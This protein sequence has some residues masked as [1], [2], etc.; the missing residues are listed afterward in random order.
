MSFT[1]G[2]GSPLSST[3]FEVVN[4]KRSQV[5]TSLDGH[6]H[7]LWSTT[8][9]PAR[10]AGRRTYIYAIIVHNRGISRQTVILSVAGVPIYP[11]VPAPSGEEQVIPLPVINVGDNDVDYQASGVDVEVQI[12][13]LEI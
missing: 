12:L 11:T 3:E 7:P 6:V 9:T 10:T 4:S 2:S 1:E 5:A 8:T 13:V